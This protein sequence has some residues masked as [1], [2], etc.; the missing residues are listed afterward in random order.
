MSSRYSVPISAMSS[1]MHMMLQTNTLWIMCN[2][3][4][5][6]NWVHMCKAPCATHIVHNAILMTIRER[7]V[8]FH[9]VNMI[10]ESYVIL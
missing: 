4:L 1:L 7:L 3:L 8:N 10:K 9:S 6:M 2:K 5:T